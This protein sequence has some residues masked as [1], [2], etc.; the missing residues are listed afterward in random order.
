VQ[1]ANIS[2]IST[3]TL[4]PTATVPVGPM[5]YGLATST[6][7]TRLL[8]ANQSAGSVSVLDAR[9]LR[10]LTTEKVGRFPEGLVVEPRGRK[11]YVAN[12]FS[13]DVSVLDI[14]GGKELKRI[15]TGGGSRAMA[16]IARPSSEG[17]EAPA[18]SSAEQRH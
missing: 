12:W 7:G 2:V 5:P 9:D 1:S 15:R 3:E 14:A 18:T 4:Q 16:V 11:A 8:V 6:D 13:G 10:V 17:I